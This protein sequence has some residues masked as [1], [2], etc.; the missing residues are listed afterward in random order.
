MVLFNTKIT[1]NDNR[2]NR[3]DM[4][5]RHQMINYAISKE[6]TM[7]TEYESK[8]VLKNAGLNVVSTDIA[9]SQ[10]EAA[11]LSERI[12]FPVVL[13]IASPDI[14]HKSDIGGV[15]IGLKNR[16]EVRKAYD[17]IT[18]SA[19]KAYPDAEIQGV[20]VQ[21]FAEPGVEVIIG[22]YRDPQFGR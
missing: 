5:N 2:N 1:G 9:Y 15:R 3:G 14:S 6:R 7:L 19:V 20:T 13:K 16:G 4:I 21:A 10:N 22:M 18:A 12:G 17:E 8:Q 11:A